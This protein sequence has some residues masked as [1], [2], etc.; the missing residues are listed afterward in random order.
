M[1]TANGR[2]PTARSVG[3]RRDDH[4]RARL[5]ALVRS[6]A[7]AIVGETLD[8][9]ITDWNPAAER[10]YGY[11]AEEVIGQHRTM[12]IPPAEAGKVD[13]LAARLHRGESIEGLETVRWT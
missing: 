9:I 7:D 11:R 5:A 6:S 8:G 4:T 10:L 1:P 12:L 3:R 2:T 13:E